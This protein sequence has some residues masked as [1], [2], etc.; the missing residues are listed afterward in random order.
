MPKTRKIQLSFSSGEID[1]QMYGRIDTQQ[2]QS[3]LAT[4]KNWMVDPRGSLRRRPGFQRVAACT[5][6]SQNSRLIPFTYSVDQQLVV[7]LTASKARFHTNGET[8]VWANFRE[9][10]STGVNTSANTITFNDAHG[11]KEGD[12]IVFY[13]EDELFSALPSPFTN[14]DG[15]Y[16]VKR[17]DAK[18]I[19]VF[20]KASDGILVP[21]ATA[22]TVSKKFY[23]FERGSVDGKVN[24]ARIYKDWDDSTNALSTGLFRSSGAASN[25]F[26]NF[27]GGNDPG[28]GKFYQGEAV[29]LVDQD[30]A[31][32]PGITT[33]LFV[34]YLAGGTDPGDGTFGLRTKEKY[35]NTQAGSSPNTWIN[36][37]TI[38]AQLNQ[39]AINNIFLRQHWRRGEYAYI[40][41]PAYATS[42]QHTVVRISEVTHSAND[43]L[44]NNPQT[45]SQANAFVVYIENK[46]SKASDDGAVSIDSPFANDE[47]FDVEY[48]QSGDVIT[49]TH[50]NHKPHDL[51]RY[52]TIDWDIEEASFEPPISAPT[53][54]TGVVVRGTAYKITDVDDSVS[55]DLWKIDHGTAGV[56]PFAIGDTVYL[57]NSTGTLASTFYQVASVDG[58][59]TG[60]G[61]SGIG[62]RNIESGELVNG[63]G[64]VTANSSYFYYV[65]NV[66]NT[67]ETYV[68]TAVNE[69]GQES[70]ASDPFTCEDNVLAS[71]GSRNDLQWNAVTGAQSYN[72]YKEVNGSFGLIGKVDFK[73]TLTAYQFEDDGIGPSMANTLLI[74]DQQ[75]D[76]SF[77]PRASARFEQRRC[78]AGSD[79][80]PRTL[81]MSRT[82]TESSFSYRIPVQADD[83]ISVDVASRE[84]HV[85]RHLV[86]VRDLLLMT[87]QG[88]FRVTAINSDAITP[89]T[90][91]LRQQSYVGSNSVHPQVV[92]DTVVFC[93]ARGGHARELNYKIESQGYA[94]GDLSLRAAHLFD[95]FTL[96]D[97]AY[98][99]APVP[100][101]WFVSSSGK[102][103][104]L[105]YIPEER[106]LSWHQHETDGSF[107]SICSISEGNY[108][109]LYAVVKR[110]SERA[111][112]RMVQ[113]REETLDS[114]VYL[115]AS[116]IKD[117]SNTTT[118]TL[119][120]TGS[121]LMK[122]GETVTVQAFDSSGSLPQLG[123][124]SSNDVGDLVELSS[125]ASKYRIKL[126][127]FIPTV[128]VTG[129]VHHTGTNDAWKAISANS[130]GVATLYSSEDHTIQNNEAIRITTDGTLP[131]GVSTGT[132][133]YAI[134]VLKTVAN[135]EFKA[136][137]NGAGYIDLGANDSDQLYIP[138]EPVK[139]IADTG[140]SLPSG[141]NETTVYYTKPMQF[142][143]DRGIGLATISG[144]QEIVF[145]SG[146]S[147][148]HT[149]RRLKS[150]QLEDD[151]GGSTAIN[152]GSD[153]GNGNHT[154]VRSVFQ[155]AADEPHGLTTG[156]AIR[157]GAVVPGGLQT[158]RIYYAIRDTNER[159]RFA[160]SASD[161]SAGTAIQ[162]TS[163]PSTNTLTVSVS[164]VPPESQYTG[165]LLDD[166]PSNLIRTPT[167]SWAFARKTFSGFS[168]FANQTIS[169]FVDGAK[170]ES[171]TVSAAGEV[172]LN[173]YAVKICGGLSYTSQ[174]KTL[175]MSLE[176]EAGAQG[177]TKNINQVS[178]RVEDCGALKVG[179]DEADLKSVS[180]LKDTELKTGEFRTHIPSTWDEEGQIVVEATGATPASLLNITTQ[181][182]IGD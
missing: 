44:I 145:G 68:V 1:T 46:S 124:F 95:G 170:T 135:S 159:F 38:N 155:E 49:L 31:A 73:E 111:V 89:S 18:T 137:S 58:T 109:T 33:P 182:S 176:I 7:E 100:M 106:V 102:L 50:P 127:S 80:L 41:V 131:T 13:A 29:E 115:D 48:D 93:S 177:R 92:N 171:V 36:N 158:N 139:L 79:V 132:T 125:G 147:G 28:D 165:T 175:P 157:T 59:T 128:E 87:Q 30:G 180:E 5:D 90:I 54:L 40:P 126:D 167:S 146:G 172:V 168:H 103:L 149:I 105:T 56:A 151:S 62:L 110:G 118:N 76:D 179:M 53:G 120:V 134:N 153:G 143:G 6:S 101:L 75:V 72:V 45:G 11:F 51:K 163:A 97:L 4:C 21:I 113:V 27:T 117:G 67:D 152:F 22:G 108:D 81:F 77:R 156:F 166:L 37:S 96:E 140:G 85:I 162:L 71:P 10:N 61:T 60:G 20:T 173:D 138:N 141:L 104:C 2:Y 148:T 8:L 47:L 116:V 119:A 23:A 181:V 74:E 57:R 150:L 123:L 130:N 133:Y 66:G 3:G 107:E 15:D 55:P 63:L 12:A 98:S 154:V 16:F 83:R 86:P 9:F 161:A 112:E 35:V 142:S 84:A 129:R 82:G 43:I 164:E 122:A 52:G 64:T 26:L 25:Y 65:S 91:A 88:E 19:K 136:H 174:A 121:G 14:P 34:D 70:L 69:R 32:I 17:V 78:F 99:K 160:A 39:T 114:A 42:L 24:D 178:I 144:G 169:V 94:T